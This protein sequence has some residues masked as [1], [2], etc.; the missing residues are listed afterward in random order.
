MPNVAS[1]V[2]F[3]AVA[4]MVVGLEVRM[5]AMTVVVVGVVGLVVVGRHH[6]SM[7]LC[8]DAPVEPKHHPGGRAGHR[9]ALVLNRSR[10]VGRQKPRPPALWPVAPR[11][12][13]EAGPQ[14]SDE[15]SRPVLLVNTLPRA[16]GS[17]TVAL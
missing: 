3:V 9:V 7:P 17:I 8:T 16:F 4:V 13:T 1:Q 2:A 10:T 6:R 14:P 15:S 12:K 5:A 11:N